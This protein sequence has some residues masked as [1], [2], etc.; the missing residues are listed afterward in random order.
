M[1]MGETGIKVSIVI[2]VLNGVK[3]IRECMDSMTAQTLSD[4][5][6]IVVDAG[7]TDGTTEILEAYAKR[8][9]RIEIIHSDKKSMGY[10]YNLG[11]SKAQGEFIGFCEADDYVADTMYERL[12]YIA[13]RHNLDYVKSDFEMFMDKEERIFLNYH[14]LAGGRTSLYK[15][16]I[17]PLHYADLIYRDVNLWNGIYKKEFLEKQKIK[18]NET[19]G[20]AFQDTGFVLQTFLAAKRAMYVQENAYRYRRD[21][22]G[23]SVY[24]PKTLSYVV[25]EA[26]FAE[27]YLSGLKVTDEYARAVIFRRFSSVFFYF[28]GRLLETGGNAEDR[29]KLAER[30]LKAAKKQY[31][32]IPYHAIAYEGLEHS[33]SWNVLMEEGWEPFDRLQKQ[34][35]RMDEMVRRKFYEHIASYPRA[36]IFGAGEIGTSLYAL[37]KNNGYEG[38]VCF[39]DN[40]NKKWGSY[41][42]GKEVVAPYE[43]PDLNDGKTVFLIA[44]VSHVEEVKKQLLSLKISDENM[45]K[46]LMVGP[47]GSMEVRLKKE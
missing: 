44:M 5:E 45:L 17:T 47:H 34:F 46:P 16:I 25:Q 21:N 32:V 12:Y 18:M 23:S 33:L 28:Y 26:E 3:Y 43:L 38:V 22:A 40:D 41:L 6:I 13:H 4:I 14:I 7:S 19:A 8:D 31:A 42:M 27:E 1:K 30:F 35:A 20:A 24:S 37:L 2:P 11:I 36:V 39:A 29:K 15:T 9:S 10:Q